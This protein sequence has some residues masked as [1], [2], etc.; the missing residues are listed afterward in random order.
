[1]TRTL[2]ISLAAVSLPTIVF[3]VGGWLMMEVSG[4]NEVLREAKSRGV[5][6]KSMS[7]SMKP[8][9][10]D[11]ESV[12][13]YWDKLGPNGRTAELRFLKIDL[14]F[15]L[16]YSTTFAFSILTLWIALGGRPGAM[17]VF[18]MV[19]VF[20]VL[21]ADWIEGYIQINQLGTYMAG[22]ELSAERLAVASHATVT[23]IWAFVLSSLIVI[24]LA[25]C[26]PISGSRLVSNAS[27]DVDRPSRQI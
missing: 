7:L 19:P 18:L 11:L 21:A 9:G 3:M 13:S 27:V 14:L 16:F 26:L 23:K 4:R 5:D 10:Y 1:M 8:R 2:L 24:G 17:L 12:K 6:L 22:G 20:V 25:I 15:A